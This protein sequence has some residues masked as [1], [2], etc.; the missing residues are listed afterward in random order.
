M[1]TI[2]QIIDEA[3]KESFPASDPP[4]WTA[5]IDHERVTKL[6]KDP[7]NKN[8]ECNKKKCVLNDTS[9]NVECDNL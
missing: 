6:Q 2:D 1:K 5:G 8:T 7:I 3:S 9:N 4:A